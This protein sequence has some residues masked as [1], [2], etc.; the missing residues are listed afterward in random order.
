MLAEDR[1][2]VRYRDRAIPC[3]CRVTFDLTRKNNVLIECLESLHDLGAGFG[4]EPFHADGRFSLEVSPDALPIECRIFHLNEQMLGPDDSRLELTLCPQGSFLLPSSPLVRVNAGIVNLPRYWFGGPRQLSF[5]LEDETW[6]F[7][8]TPVGEQSFQ[9][10]RKIQNDSFSFSHH[11]TLK[12]RNAHPFS[13]SQVEDAL[14]LL[15]TFLSFC[16][17]RWV[18]PT[19]ITGFEASGTVAHQNWNTPLVDP[20]RDP[21]NWLD[22]YDGHPMVNVFP[23][24]SRLMAEPKWRDTIRSAVYWYVRSQSDYVGPDGAIILV[25]AALERLAWHLLVQQRQAISQN[26]FSKIPAADQIRLLLNISSIP[27]ALPAFLAE[28]SSTAKARNWTDGPEAFVA[29]RNQ[30]VHPPRRTHTRLSAR[31]YY[32]ALQLGKW[33]LELILLNATGF[34]GKYSNRLKIPRWKG[35]VEF[36]P[37]GA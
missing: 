19:L 27:L 25:Q 20:R 7:E 31:S 4:F 34:S 26:G 12:K 22:E 1:F 24:F 32:E 10:P 8:F 17:E 33:Y 16:A 29:V 23:G 28:L 2:T 6:N 30:I 5:C 37:W 13:Q 18:A 11:L 15:S 21:I 35:D 14:G 36:L 9:Y 3:R